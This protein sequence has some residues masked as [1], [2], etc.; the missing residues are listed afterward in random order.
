MVQT[1][2][3]YMML[4]RASSEPENPSAMEWAT[5]AFGELEDAIQQRGRRDPYP[6]H[7]MGSQGL[8]WVRRAL[9]PDDE[10][11]RILT[12]LR[13]VMQDARRFHPSRNELRQLA[14]DVEREYLMMSLPPDQRSRPSIQP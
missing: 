13:Q 10:K 3:S 9:I 2:W 11:I 8:S 6:Y 14:D 1:E 12:A 7:V 5:A 4:K